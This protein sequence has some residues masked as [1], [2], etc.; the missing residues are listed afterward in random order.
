MST[1]I[2]QMPVDLIS[3]VMCDA[4]LRHLGQV[5]YFDIIENLRIEYGNQR[6]KKLGRRKFYKMSVKFFKEHNYHTEFAKE[7]LQP[8]KEKNFKLLQKRIIMLEEKR[9]QI[10]QQT[11]FWKSILS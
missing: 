6:G 7:N 1:T 11:C 4:D 3:K 10:I 9:P 5:E 8:T 2:P